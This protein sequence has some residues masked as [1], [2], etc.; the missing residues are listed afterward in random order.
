MGLE[1]TEGERRGRPSAEAWPMSGVG[2]GEAGGVNQLELAPGRAWGNRQI[3]STWL[4]HSVDAGTEAGITPSH[5][6]SLLEL[7][8]S[9][10]I[11]SVYEAGQGEA[12]PASLIR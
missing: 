11:A 4:S 5:I 12:T 6:K 3:V 2:D 8:L 1:D 7:G 9:P 10:R